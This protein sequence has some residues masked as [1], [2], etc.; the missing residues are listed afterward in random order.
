MGQY[1]WLCRGVRCGAVPVAVQGDKVWGSTCGC[2]GGTVPA[3]VKGGQYIATVQ[4]GQYLWLRRGDS[5]CGC[6]EGAVLWLCRGVRSG[7]VPVA[8]C[9]GVVS[10]GAVPVAVRRGQYLRLCRGVRC[11]AVPAA[12]Q[13]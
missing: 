10:C 7:A 11:G 13:G 3:G 1:L 4:G 5:T 12:V 6:A 8:V 9:A 2:A